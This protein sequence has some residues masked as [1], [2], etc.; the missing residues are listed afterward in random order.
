MGNIHRGFHEERS[1]LW[2]GDT[3]GH[4]KKNGHK[5][6]CLILNGHRA[7]LISRPNPVGFLFVGLDY[8]GYERKVDTRDELLARLS[9]VAARVKKREN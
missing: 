5:D 3:I 6:M 4:C 7:V 8:E 1:T 9:N 2:R